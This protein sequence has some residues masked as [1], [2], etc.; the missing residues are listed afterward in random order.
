MYARGHR[1]APLNEQLGN[2]SGLET[3]EGRARLFRRGP[4]AVPGPFLRAAAHNVIGALWEVSDAYTP[5][6]MELRFLPR[7]TFRARTHAT[8]LRDASLR[9]AAFR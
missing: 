4:G 6:M 3:G 7:I 5:Q 8:A 1:A 9:A 2:Q